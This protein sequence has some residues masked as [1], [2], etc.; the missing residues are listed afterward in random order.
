MYTVHKITD[1]PYFDLPTSLTIGNFDALHRGHQH[2]ISRMKKKSMLVT[3]VTFS[4]FPEKPLSSI[5]S[6]KQKVRLLEML[7]IDNL[8]LLPFAEI[9]S[10]TFDAFLDEI[11][12]HFSSLHLVLGKNSFFGKNREGNEEKVLAFAE[13]RK[14]QVEYLPL[15]TEEKETISST[16]I[17]LAIVRGD[18][19]LLQKLLDRPF[20]YFFDLSSAHTFFSSP[21]SSKL[22]LEFSLK[23]QTPL[24]SGSYEVFVESGENH[25]STIASLTEDRLQ[26]VLAPDFISKG[27]TLQVIFCSK[28]RKESLF[29]QNTKDLYV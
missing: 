1:L 16:R 23:N 21:Y 3:L 4:S 27:A 6:Q 28:K 15:I 11:A 9:S 22:S 14:M 24:P 19:A 8:L 20:S 17:R 25:V 13:Q 26:M 10:L 7:G 18:F 12:S 29:L 2:L 5:F